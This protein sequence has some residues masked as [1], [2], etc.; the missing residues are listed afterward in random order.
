VWGPVSDP[1]MRSKAPQRSLLTWGQPRPAV[2][3]VGTGDLP[4]QSE[5]SSPELL[6]R[7]AFKSL[8][9]TWKSVSFFGKEPR[10]IALF[11]RPDRLG[12]GLSAQR[13]ARKA[14]FC[15]SGVIWFHNTFRSCSIRV[16]LGSLRSE[17][18]NQR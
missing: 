16:L 5:Q 13:S 14:S 11:G 2:A 4:V 17:R 6:K 9:K 8:R 7:H 15:S 18:E 10:R 1:S 3:S 12:L